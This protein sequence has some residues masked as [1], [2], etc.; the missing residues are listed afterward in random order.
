VALPTA[1]GRLRR[2]ERAGAR[3]GRIE[4]ARVIKA[5]GVR[6]IKVHGLRH[7]SATLML[8]AGEPVH[9]V[10]ARLGHAKVTTT[11]E[12]YAHALPS[13]GQAAALRMGRLLYGRNG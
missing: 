6:A 4:F 12:T 8:A 3:P 9:V 5:A 11:L 13:H 1:E 7:T 2:R 10:A